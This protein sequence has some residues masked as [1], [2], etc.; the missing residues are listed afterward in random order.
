[1]VMLVEPVGYAPRLIQVQPA[2][3]FC[4]RW[5]QCNGRCWLQLLRLVY[6]VQELNQRGFVLHDGGALVWGCQSGGKCNAASI[7]RNA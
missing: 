6:G 1:M 3:G 4:W 5:W 2:H 7:R